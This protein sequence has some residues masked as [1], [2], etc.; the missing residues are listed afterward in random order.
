M[1]YSIAY[2]PG[3]LGQSSFLV[4]GGAGFI[5][6]N[7]VEYL[8][9]HGAG[10]VVVLDNLSNGFVANLAP[11]LENPAFSWIQGD[12][13]D[14]E[15]CR[16]AC[17]GIDYV[18]HQAALGS[19]P[20]SVADPVATNAANVNGTLIL[21][22]AAKDAGVKRMVF[23][24][25][26]SVYGDD[27]HLPKK[28]HLT[29]RLLSPYAVSKK[30]AELYGQVFWHTYGFKVAGLRYFNVFG[31]RQ[32]FGVAYAAV[33]PLFAKALLNGQAP[34]I[35]G[36]GEQ[37]RDFTFVENVVQANIRALFATDE[38]LWGS[39]IN[40]GNGQT[41]S[42]NQLAELVARLLGKDIRPGY[43]PPRKGDIRDSLADI[44]LAQELIG[45]DPLFSF[46]QGLGLTMGWYKELFAQTH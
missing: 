44:S 19:V 37:S 20:R 35:Y 32:S 40:I 11:F 24:S 25:S 8:L 4:T 6:S 26:S 46:E 28:E 9:T 7:L 39:V 22:T 31:P 45:Y 16:R 43:A 12:I 17:H 27:P 21:M 42:V 10:R 15:T 38:R 33:I 18:L 3:S 36:D 34:L 2:H 13:T 23:A 14:P 1:P 41:T 5:G 29:G 30:T